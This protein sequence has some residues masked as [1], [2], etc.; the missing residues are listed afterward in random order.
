L[1]RIPASLGTT[2]CSFRAAFGADPSGGGSA[3][4]V[5]AKTV[6]ALAL[7]LCVDLRPKGFVR[8]V[9]VIGCEPV[10]DGNVVPN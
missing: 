10:V 4:E 7:E 8:T 2:L 3:Q 5:V 1:R 9:G 6:A